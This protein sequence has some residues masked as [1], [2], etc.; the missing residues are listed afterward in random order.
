MISTAGSGQMLPLPMNEIIQQQAKP[1][2]F[3][4]EFDVVEWGAMIIAKRTP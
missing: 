3:D 1:L 2:G 4:L